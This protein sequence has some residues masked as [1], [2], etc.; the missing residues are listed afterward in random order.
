MSRVRQGIEA[1]AAAAS[2]YSPQVCAMQ[3]A[4]GL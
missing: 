2:V 3:A 4:Q 1:V